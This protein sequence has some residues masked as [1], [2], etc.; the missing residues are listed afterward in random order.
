M[1]KIILILVATLFIGSLSGQ[2]NNLGE[3][4]TEDFDEYLKKT[5]W[6]RAIDFFS[7]MS[8]SWVNGRWYYMLS[9]EGAPRVKGTPHHA[10]IYRK[11]INGSAHWEV[12]SN[13]LFTHTCTKEDHMMAYDWYSQVS[14]G[15]ALDGF[16]SYCQHYVLNGEEVIIG[17]LGIHGYD[18][19]NSVF[20]KTKA[21]ILYPIEKNEVTGAVKYDMFSHTID[22]IFPIKEIEGNKLIDLKDRYLEYVWNDKGMKI[23][24]YD[25]EKTI[26]FV[27]DK[28]RMKAIQ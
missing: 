14:Y 4:Q 1:K 15:S 17:L 6:E 8:T 25:G 3:P 2:I 9:Y 7:P 16:T 11:L 10:Y 27:K 13:R 22:G 21:Y 5:N 18:E 12:A 23:I 24:F 26:H 28:I 20:L 19:N